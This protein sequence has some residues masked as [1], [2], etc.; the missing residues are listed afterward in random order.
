MGKKRVLL[1]FVPTVDFV[2]EEDRLPADFVPTL[3]GPLDY[4]A[5]F[6]YAGC[7]RAKVLERRSG[8]LSNDC[9]EGRL[10]AAGLSPKNRGAKAVFFDGLAE[11]RPGADY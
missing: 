10:A 6:R 7:Y 4:L 5:N 8:G 11:Q 1:G 2:D 9:G 3:A